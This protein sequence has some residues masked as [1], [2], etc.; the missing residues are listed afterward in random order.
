MAENTENAQTSKKEEKWL[1]PEKLRIF[2]IRKG[3]R[4][5]KN[6]SSKDILRLTHC[7]NLNSYKSMSGEALKEIAK[8]GD[9]AARVELDRRNRKHAKKNPAT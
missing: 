5:P 6:R 1:D 3:Q 9:F 2:R 4:K 7:N 8:N